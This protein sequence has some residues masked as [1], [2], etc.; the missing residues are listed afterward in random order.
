MLAMVKATQPDKSSHYEIPPYL[1]GI[2]DENTLNRFKSIMK[3]KDM[4]W[5]EAGGYAWSK[6]EK[7]PEL[8]EIIE[9]VRDAGADRVEELDFFDPKIHSL[10]E[11]YINACID[12]YFAKR[13]KMD[14]ENAHLYRSLLTGDYIVDITICNPD[15]QDY[16]A[17][18]LQKHLDPREFLYGS[19]AEVKK[20]E[21]FEEEGIPKV[22]VKVYLRQDN[23]LRYNTF[24][25][26]ILGMVELIE[27]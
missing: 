10:D 19:V 12:S 24:I 9:K 23:L 14:F 15:S 8:E 22:N 25:R 16:S 20:V 26:G 1:R 11:G 5:L 4:L 7:I 17:E 2:L 21:G 3:D 27:I 18:G 6:S 13:W